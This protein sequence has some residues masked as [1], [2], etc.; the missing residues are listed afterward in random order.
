[1]V[2][3]YF[4]KDCVHSLGHLNFEKWKITSIGEDRE[5][6]K[7]AYIVSGNVEWCSHCGK[8]F[9]DSSKS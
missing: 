5:K 1:M 8:R 3:F 6:L 7:P 2:Y 9:G 4:T